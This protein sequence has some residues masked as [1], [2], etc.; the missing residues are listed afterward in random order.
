MLHVAKYLGDDTTSAKD[1]ERELQ[2]LLD[3]AQPGWRDVLVERRFLP[4]LIVVNALAT[5]DTGGLKG[6]PDVATDVE[7]VYLAG[8]W[9]GGEGWL[10]DAS[11]A[12]AKGAATAALAASAASEATRTPI[13]AG[14][15]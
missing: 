9:V 15:G 10:V 6:R 12:S 7:G 11:L 1:V 4:N 5:A 13:E 8:D 2:D 14:T 3:L